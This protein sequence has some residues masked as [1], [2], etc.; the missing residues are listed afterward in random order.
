MEIDEITRTLSRMADWQMAHEVEDNNRHQE[1]LL[2]F[3]AADARSAQ[4]TNA[5]N[6]IHKAL[7]DHT[8][9]LRDLKPLLQAAAGGKIA[10][11]VFT[12]I[13]SLAV[14]WLAIKNTFNL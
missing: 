13:G 6:D 12:F 5:L 8:D 11:R 3:K 10:Y 9:M 4:M 1:N 14:A 7:Q 2:R